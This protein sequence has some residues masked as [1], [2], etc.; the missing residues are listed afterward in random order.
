VIDFQ[1]I[2]G[3]IA[4]NACV[5]AAVFFG[6]YIFDGTVR[7]SRNG[8][9]TREPP[10]QSSFWRPPAVSDR[11]PDVPT[12][13]APTVDHCLQAPLSTY[14]QQLRRRI[15]ISFFKVHPSDVR[16]TREALAR[17]LERLVPLPSALVPIG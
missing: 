15:G 17:P 12:A 8:L 5:L 10:P 3:I 14:R 4:V 1:I 2:F 6:A 11:H 7:S 9:P 16:A 13:L